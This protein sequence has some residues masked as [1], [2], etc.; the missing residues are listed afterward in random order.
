MYDK[1]SYTD[2]SVDI[3]TKCKFILEFKND[4]FKL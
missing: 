1:F 3:C 4:L 2:F